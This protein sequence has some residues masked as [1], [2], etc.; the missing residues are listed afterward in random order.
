MNGIG[1]A[2]CTTVDMAE[3]EPFLQSTDRPTAPLPTPMPWYHKGSV[4]VALGAVGLILLAG[5][6][7]AV[8]TVSERSG[9]PPVTGTEVTTSAS[10]SPPSVTSLP[11]TPTDVTPLPSTDSVPPPMVTVTAE[12][13]DTTTAPTAAEPPTYPPYPGSS[14]WRRFFPRWHFGPQQ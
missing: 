3:T 8:V 7:I 5:L 14:P 11:T 1:T 12:T 6:V 4:V 13:E 2:Q 9:E 10:P